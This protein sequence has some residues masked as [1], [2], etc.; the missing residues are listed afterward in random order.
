MKSSKSSHKKPSSQS[1]FA[2][3]SEIIVVR[4]FTRFPFEHHKLSMNVS[5]AEQTSMPTF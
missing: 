5:H 1:L 3:A 4:H 2:C